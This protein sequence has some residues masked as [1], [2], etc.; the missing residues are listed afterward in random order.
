MIHNMMIMLEAFTLQI[1]NTN[2]SR[3]GDY[4]TVRRFTSQYDPPAPYVKVRILHRFFTKNL[5]ATD[6]VQIT[7]YIYSK[8]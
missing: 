6:F 7:N 1:N 3:H 2:L 4:W 8:V 5:L